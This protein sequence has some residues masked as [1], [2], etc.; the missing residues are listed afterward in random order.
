MT[1]LTT[2]P[3][4][5]MDTP[6]QIA[7]EDSSRKITILTSKEGTCNISLG[8][9]AENHDLISFPLTE[10]KSFIPPK[11]IS[12]KIFYSGTG[13]KLLF[14]QNIDSKVALPLIKDGQVI[15]NANDGKTPINLSIN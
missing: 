13:S 7:I 3:F 11:P 5:G 14:I 10:G 1:I 12:S 2:I 4:V 9:D 6:T 8:V 15:V